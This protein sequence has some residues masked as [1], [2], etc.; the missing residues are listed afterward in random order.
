MSR[1]VGDPIVFTGNAHPQLARDV[2][3][4]LDVEL[5]C[6]NVFDFANGNT[7]VQFLEN[8]RERDVF[9]IQPG[10]KPVNHHLVE[11]LIMIDAARRASAGRITAVVPYFA[12]GRSDKKDQPRVPITARLFA[13]LIQ[14]A[15]A[16]RMLT[17]D[18]H[19]GQIQGFFHIP[20]DELTAQ[21][22]MVEHFQRRGFDGVVVSPDFGGAKRARAA[23]DLLGMPVAIAEKRRTSNDD[24]AEMLQLIGDVVDRDV[25]II[26]DEIVTAGTLCEVAEMLRGQGARSIWAAAIHGILPHPALE[27]LAASPI[28]SVVLTDTLPLPQERRGAMLETVSIAPLLGEA[29]RR[30]HEGDSVGALFR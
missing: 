24:R 3:A 15:G 18:L 17:M 19:A 21:Q 9:L 27:R 22:L 1:Y 14:T 23:A 20:T 25:L 28:A 8:I 26:D 29:I 11:L 7:F 2:C 4:A 6:A 5:G 12:Y 10:A 16:D 30:I 13:D